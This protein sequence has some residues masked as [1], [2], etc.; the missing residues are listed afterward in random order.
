MGEEVSKLEEGGADEG[1]HM[2]P[3]RSIE[4]PQVELYCGAPH[5]MPCIWRDAVRSDL[6]NLTAPFG[7]GAPHWTASDQDS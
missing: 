1:H 5:A 6:D 4:G 3:D 7:I 2:Q